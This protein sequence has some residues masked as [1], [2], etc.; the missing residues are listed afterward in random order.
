MVDAASKATKRDSV[1]DM[2]RGDQES[3]APEI[4]PEFADVNLSD[5]INRFERQVLEVFLQ[6]P[7]SAS[8]AEAERIMRSGFS[9]PAHAAI[10]QVMLSSLD[11]MQDANWLA[12]VEENVDEQLTGLVRAIAAQPLPAKDASS[13]VRYAEGVIAR[14]VENTIARQKADLLAE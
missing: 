12:L 1:A 14:A 2:R 7:M 4:E 13:L 8:S 10:A 3:V 5:P 6:S 9:A 11:R